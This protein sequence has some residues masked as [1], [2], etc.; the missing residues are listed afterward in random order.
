MAAPSGTTWGSTVGGKGRIGLYTSLSSTNTETTLTVQIWF[1]SKYSVSD[2][3][4]KLYY[5]NL[6]SS[7]KASTSKGEVDIKTTV[8]TGSGW[9]T[10]NQKKL[11]TY[12]KTY[13]RTTS[14]QTRYL[15]A[16]LT[17]ID[18]VGGTMSVSKTVSIPKLPTYTIKY[19][20]NGGSSTPDNQTKYY[21]KAIKLAKA[22]TRT[23]YTFQG[24]G[25]SASDTTVDYKAEASYTTN[26]SDTFYAIWKINTYK[27]TFD[28]NGGT[29][30]PTSQTKTY[31]KDL[32]LTT[33]APSRT[34]FDFL[35]WSTSKTA[36]SATYPTGK[37]NVY[38]DNKA[39]TLYAVW[40]K[41]TYTVT[42]DAKGGT[43]S[44]TSH[45]KTYDVALK[46]ATPTRTGYIFKGWATSS[47]STS[48]AYAPG[49]N[50]TSNAKITLYAVWEIEY[51]K[52]TIS[53]LQVSR[54]DG[55]GNPV[56]DDVE[57]SSGLVSFVWT[58][59]HNV[60]SI[61]VAWKSASGDISGSSSVPNVTGT[62]D[63]VSY[64]FGNNAL[65]MD[66]TFTV[67]VT[68]ED[69]GG[70]TP[71]TITLEGYVFTIDM[72]G[73]GNG[74][75]F[76]KPAEI[77]DTADFNFD[78]RAR[79]RIITENDKGVYGKNI[80]G[81]DVQLI[82]QSKNN[83]TVVGYSNYEKKSG[84]S[85]I[86]GHDLMHYVSNLATPTGYRP[87]RRRG[88]TL[89]Y[90]F[91][92]AGFVTNGGTEVHF[93]YPLSTPI[94]GDP[95]VTVTSDKG[96]ILRQNG[97]YTHGSTSNTYVNTQVS[98]KATVLTYMGV[99]V[100]ATFT[101]TANVINNAP[102]GILWDGIVTFS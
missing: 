81:T 87:Y 59:F 77:E 14:A 4:N 68:V 20:A 80:D 24:W 79:K 89:S 84:N 95:I 16:K 66:Q 12:T 42:Y 15:Y 22:I 60:S 2:S 17:N 86:Y 53:N 13:D 1:W 50:Y 72:L 25:T 78:I 43:V 31:G 49:A 36:T 10:S 23:G 32:T 34:G 96:F 39:I 44:P 91:Y 99:Y 55:S 3:N 64:R 40:K 45:T 33:S 67:T 82:S 90:T 38:K 29:G 71:K 70:N 8:A 5:D 11:K 69:S 35:G 73:G 57:K 26:A 102:I 85:H 63:T 76:G 61:T 93:I 62:G 7:G 18:V 56:G 100:V 46:L 101:N 28:A 75:A 37:T 94:Y 97:L 88:D 54:C 9:S 74:V 47:T 41:K 92:G 21:G 27:V 19:N 65:P 51:K 52:P 98:Y 6:A 58:T 48:V 30:G 83:N